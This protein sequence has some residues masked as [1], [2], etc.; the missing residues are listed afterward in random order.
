MEN[1]MSLNILEHH[2]YTLIKSNTKGKDKKKGKKSKRGA[3]K[4]KNKSFK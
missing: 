2:A 3:R 4:H 1:K